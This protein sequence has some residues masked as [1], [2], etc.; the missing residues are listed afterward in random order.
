MTEHFI[1]VKDTG[2]LHTA[3]LTD[4]SY[5]NQR[6]FGFAQPYNW[7]QVLAILRRLRPDHNLPEDLEDDSK[8]VS[9]VENGPA[10]KILQDRFGQTDWV[11]LEEALKENIA[12]IH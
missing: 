5:N 1:S 8:D 6:I 11:G 4:A 9:T 12:F 3:L 7:N 2:R 10:L